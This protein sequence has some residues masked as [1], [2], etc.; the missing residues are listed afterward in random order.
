MSSWG[1]KR[2]GLVMSAGFFGF[3]GHAGFWKR[4][5]A[6]GLRP[7]ACVGSSRE[8]GGIDF[9]LGREV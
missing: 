8:G 5:L 9:V 2:F 7:H 1:G 4:L 6:T 3:Y